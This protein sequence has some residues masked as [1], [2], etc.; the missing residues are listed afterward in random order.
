MVILVKET[1]VEIFWSKFIE[2]G[3]SLEVYKGI[4]KHF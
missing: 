3:I 4:D 2:F 1:I